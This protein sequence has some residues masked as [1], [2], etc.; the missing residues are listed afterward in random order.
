MREAG[1]DSH[2][3]LVPVPMF[4]FGFSFGGGL[5]VEERKDV[6]FSSF[7]RWVMDVS[8]LVNGGW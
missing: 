8:V 1:I 4:A 2:L 6:F 3:C 5:G 7:Q